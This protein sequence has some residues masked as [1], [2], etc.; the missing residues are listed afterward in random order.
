MGRDATKD[1]YSVTRQWVHFSEKAHE[2]K[3]VNEGPSL[4][5]ATRKGNSVQEKVTGTGFSEPLNSENCKVAVEHSKASQTNQL[6]R[7]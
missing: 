3:S 5:T 7:E 2:C 1:V 6:L 4:R